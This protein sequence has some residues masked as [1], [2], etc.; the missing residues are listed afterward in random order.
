M[1]LRKENGWAEDEM[2]LAASHNSTK[3]QNTGS[4]QRKTARFKGRCC[5]CGKFGHKKVDCMDCLKLPK[6]EQD[7]ADKEHQEKSEEKPKKNKDH[8]NCNKMG[9]NTSECPGKKPKDSS[10][11]TRGGSAMMCFEV[12]DS[13]V[14]GELEQTSAHHTE[15]LHSEVHSEVHSEGH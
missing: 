10:G 14:E 11:G 8:V 7:R 4:N 5:H 3:N 13:P 9:H 1:Q 6:E 2:A 15:Q 12:S